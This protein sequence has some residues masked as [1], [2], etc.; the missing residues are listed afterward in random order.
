MLLPS[1]NNR[2]RAVAHALQSISIA[3]APPI[4]I[5]IAEDDPNVRSLVQNVVTA[6]GHAPSCAANGAEALELY[7]AR[8]ADVVVSDWMMP[9][10]DGVQLCRCVRARLGA[11]YTYF[12]LLTA[13]AVSDHRIAGM[14]AGA[15]DYLAKP[16]NLADIEAR[17]IAA[18][19]VTVVHR[20]REAL[21]RQARSFA[22]ETDPARLL[23]N[24]LREAI[25]LVGG[26]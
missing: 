2:S 10:M 19:R 13:L 22:A 25:A 4:Q 6:L 21:L 15:D 5:L 8:G 9:R 11:P 12:I 26:S 7:N 20:R 18:E 17:L 14:Q 1:L 23:D 24:L 3:E 16:F